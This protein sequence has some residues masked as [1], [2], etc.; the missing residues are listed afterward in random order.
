MPTAEYRE[1]IKQL[2]GAMI[3][4]SGA[5]TARPY[6]D[7]ANLA[8]LESDPIVN[9]LARPIEIFGTREKALRWL[10]TPVRSL[11]DKTPISLLNTTEGLA[12]VQDTLGR[13]EHGVW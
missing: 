10:R 12:R 6:S 2:V 13:V 1:E 9:V 5:S 7:G 3:A 11:G 8:L 4:E